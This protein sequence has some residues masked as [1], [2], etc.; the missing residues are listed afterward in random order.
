LDSIRQECG[1]SGRIA[2]VDANSIAEQELGVPITNTTMIG[3]LLKA[4]PGL[5]EIESLHYPLEERFGAN[6]AR[7]LKALQRAFN[8]TIM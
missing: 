2:K 4:C 8:E 5:V 6:A 3:A 7:N 1:F